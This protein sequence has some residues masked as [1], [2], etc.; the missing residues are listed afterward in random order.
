[1]PAGE[2]AERLRRAVAAED[3][4]TISALATAI[5]PDPFEVAARMLF[6]PTPDGRPSATD[7]QA[8]ARFAHEA[9]EGTG[10]R[11]FLDHWLSAPPEA[12]ARERELWRVSARVTMHRKRGDLP[13]ALAAADAAAEELAAGRHSHQ[14]PFVRRL[15]ALVLRALGRTSE[16]VDALAELA[17]VL[18]DRE[19]PALEG[20][21]RL[22]LVDALVADGRPEEQVLAECKRAERLL[23]ESRT[24]DDLIEVLGFT[25]AAELRL[26]RLPE[27]E[28]TVYRAVVIARRTGRVRD[29]LRSTLN[30]A[31]V[32]AHMGRHETA[33][34]LR[35][36][37]FDRAR[38]QGL[39][40][41]AAW[42]AQVLAW[43]ELSTGRIAAALTYGDWLEDH[44]DSLSSRWTRADTSLVLG[45]LAAARGRN[46]TAARHY[47]DAL[48]HQR[49]AG[50]PARVFTALSRLVRLEGRNLPGDETLSSYREAAEAAARADDTLPVLTEWSWQESA[51]GE[52]DVAREIAQRAMAY[53]ARHPD[54]PNA[55]LASLQMAQI[56]LAER[57]WDDAVS[58]LEALPGSMPRHEV[59]QL[60]LQRTLGRAYAGQ[61][62]WEEAVSAFRRT[63]E[64]RQ[65]RR[66]GLALRDALSQR[67]DEH[68]FA[69]EGM[70]AACAWHAAG[71]GEPALAAAW[72]FHEMAS[73]RLLASAIHGPAA[74]DR[75]GPDASAFLSRV[76]SEVEAAH[77]RVV[78][79]VLSGD[80][81]T[82]Q[83]ARVALHEAYE[84]LA[85]V[86]ARATRRATD[87]MAARDPLP[88][89]RLQADLEED[90]ALLAYAF[91][92]QSV[93]GLVVTSDGA[94]IRKLG[95]T[96]EIQRL[97]SRWHQLVSAPGAPE[98]KLSARLYESLLR[99][100]EDLAAS[101]PHWIVLPDGAL[102]GAPLDAWIRTNGAGASS[103]RVIESHTVTYA[104]AH[105]IVKA[106]QTRRAARKKGVGLL[107]LGD[108]APAL[109]GDR[110]AGDWQVV[111]ALG[112]GGLRMPPLPS[113]R[114]E[115][116]AVAALYPEAERILL[117]AADATR[118]RWLDALPD[119]GHPLDCAHFAC[120]GLVDDRLPSLSGLV[121]A[122]G[123]M[124]TAERLQGT[125][126]PADLVVLSAC[127][128][129]GGTVAVGEGL[130]G[131]TR[132]FLR[133]GAT[134]VIC[135]TWQI[136]DAST[137][138]IMVRFHRARRE[139]KLSDAQALRQARLGALR[140]A[141]TA[142][143]Y[144]WAGFQLWGA[145]DP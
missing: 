141:E 61:G 75:T 3:D 35:H 96:A 57:R 116:R 58:L 19:W 34:T 98:G 111:A 72:W 103:E 8:L 95:N 137:A 105:G 10:V 24:W 21:V 133:A 107:V 52:S 27:A 15:R 46:A 73:G 53:A 59:W 23:T 106:L 97:V 39:T 114:A 118:A 87:P 7:R 81:A 43:S 65:S 74:S 127:H 41:L 83:E 20:R 104:H 45:D 140:R 100:F 119:P 68:T 66:S 102:S 29:L 122:G 71:G 117:L 88:F 55:P 99:P 79:S 26:F 112:H 44:A 76:L 9:S 70:E 90:T 36:R 5:W 138:D 31:D 2:A 144:Y 6:P 22:D 64:R 63:V 1:M 37:A 13:A 49:A 86:E 56:A 32:A 80:E 145:R 51:I 113:S 77:D 125:S 82:Q 14:G 47:L 115:A 134:R 130:L 139:S 89:A 128:S 42:A 48:G 85:R 18:A 12:F 28:E 17:D 135:T 94:R 93:T 110:P 25:S 142:H 126:V 131:L 67:A 132:A 92:P 4:A 136:Q 143:P 62:R 101:R 120:H 108:P 123:E 38:E 16:A 121:F 69:A 33:S 109:G 60:R 11:A 54:D 78:R 40:D 124:L 129:G 50:S 91:G 84:R 30:L